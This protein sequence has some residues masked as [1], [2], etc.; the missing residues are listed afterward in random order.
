MANTDS[1]KK[2]MRIS[3]KK[4]AEN[5]AWYNKLKSLGRKFQ[6][7]VNEKKKEAAQTIYKD[8]QKSF[9]AAAKRNVIHKNT[10]ARKKS[11]LSAVLQKLG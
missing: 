10:A 2:Y 7:A 4:Q 6:K 8:L 11:R 3:A 1:A 9:D 5:D